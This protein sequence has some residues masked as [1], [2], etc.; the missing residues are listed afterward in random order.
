MQPRAVIVL[1][2]GV[3][4]RRKRRDGAVAV[5]HRL[6]DRGQREPGGGEARRGFHH[7]LQD[8]GRGGG[9]AALQIIQRPLV[10]PVGDQ[11]AG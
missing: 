8:I 4:R 10:A 9:I 2:V 3:A 11:I 1:A 6:A 7:L 5:A